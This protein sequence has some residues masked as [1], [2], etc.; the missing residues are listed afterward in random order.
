MGQSPNA[1][2]EPLAKPITERLLQE[3]PFVAYFSARQLR[4]LGKLQQFVFRYPQIRDPQIPL[5]RLLGRCG[6]GNV[7]S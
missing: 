7:R 3:S 1:H 6:I 5:R 2:N 4:A